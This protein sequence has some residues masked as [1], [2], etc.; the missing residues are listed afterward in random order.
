MKIGRLSNG[1]KHAATRQ[2][3]RREAEE[4]G[5]QRK[6]EKAQSVRESN[7]GFKKNDRE[8]RNKM[9]HNLEK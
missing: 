1:G 2:T 4:V 5:L 8:K 7:P 9:I 3:N 6:L